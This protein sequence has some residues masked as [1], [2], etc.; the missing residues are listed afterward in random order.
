MKQDFLIA[1]S[2]SQYGNHINSMVLSNGNH[3]RR[4]VDE[5]K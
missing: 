5:P 1:A 4:F 3:Y 2:T